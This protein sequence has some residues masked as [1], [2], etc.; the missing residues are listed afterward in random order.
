MNLL[1]TGG[2]GFIG[3]HLVKA[4]AVEHNIHV[5]LPPDLDVILPNNV[6]SIVFFDN[7]SELNN[8]I[9]KNEIEGI[10]HLATL[11]IAQH[12][13]ENIK[14]LILS[15]VFLGTALLEAVEGSKVKWF[16]NTGTIW[17]NY[18]PNCRRYHPTNLYAAT[19]QAFID[20]AAYY[21]ETTRLKFVT[22]KLSDTFGDGDTRRKLFTILKEAS[23]TGET[24]QMSPGEQYLDILHIQ[25]IISGFMHLIQLLNDNKKLDA[26]YVLAARQRYTLKEVV[27]LF[28]KVSD[29]KLTINWGGRPYRKREIMQP[30]KKGKLLPD[31]QASL[32]LEEGI[33][34]YLKKSK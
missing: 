5:L 15:N 34:L 11:F 14:D 32:S 13:P 27:T 2:T 18:R 33:A 6:H 8:Y 24:I 1:V 25:D 29:K 21:V 19:K 23:M 17:Q 7:I 20:M 28:E 10:V 4:L 16:L 30:W 9:I 22:L 31:W 3:T 26:E 12:Q